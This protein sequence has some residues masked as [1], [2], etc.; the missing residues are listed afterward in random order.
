MNN[1]KMNN[2]Q[3]TN[4]N[5]EYDRCPIKKSMI[6]V[7]R[8]EV[9]YQYVEGNVSNGI[10]VGAAPLHNLQIQFSFIS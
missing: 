7:R 6:R 8:N 3:C 5:N 1:N 2:K 4:K 10:Y 9:G